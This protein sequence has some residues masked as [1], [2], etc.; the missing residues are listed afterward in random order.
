MKM[1]ERMVFSLNYIQWINQF[2]VILLLN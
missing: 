1:K 2:K